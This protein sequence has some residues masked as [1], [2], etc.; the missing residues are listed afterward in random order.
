MDGLLPKSFVNSEA[1]Q[2]VERVEGP[3]VSMK[4]QFFYFGEELTV[5]E[6][7]E[8]LIHYLNSKN[9][10]YTLIKT[11]E[12]IASKKKSNFEMYSSLGAK[13]RDDYPVPFYPT[14]VKLPYSNVYMNRTFAISNIFKSKGILEVEAKSKTNLFRFITIEWQIGGSANEARLFNRKQL[15]GVPAEFVELREQ[16]PEL[17]LHESKVLM[18]SGVSSMSKLLQHGQNFY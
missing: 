9:V 11:G 8:Y 17:Q 15:D 3:F 10:K 13:A 18:V 12:E 14:S 16:L 7:S 1:L 2:N 5:L 4:N 6:G